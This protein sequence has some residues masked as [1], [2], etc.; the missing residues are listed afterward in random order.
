MPFA[1]ITG[2]SKGIGRSIAKELAARKIDVLLVARTEK[3]L[4]E[5][6]VELINLYG[7]K[8]Y[9]L[10]IDLAQPQAARKVYDWSIERKF[11]VNILVNNAG[12]GLSGDFEKYS[13][14]DYMDMMQVNIIA[15]VELICLFLSGL[16]KQSKAYILNIGSSAAYQS[17][18]YL[19]IYSGSKAF[20]V[21]FSRA[22]KYELNKT[23]VSVTLVSPGTTITE[24]SE[25]ANVPEKSI[26]AGKKISMTADQVAKIAVKSLFKEKTEVI[27]GFIT[28]LTIFLV[29]LLPKK[30]VERT[31]A[32]FY[33]KI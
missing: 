23:N 3:L 25:R 10:S 15:P 29:W 20:I 30:L 13:R 22:L 16:K 11:T 8:A 9:C 19:S 6:A 17:V 2:A 5:L 1:L 31:G 33:K 12:Y 18:P 21:N 14:E 32:G 4:N 24:F 28:K 26:K 7:I 27:T